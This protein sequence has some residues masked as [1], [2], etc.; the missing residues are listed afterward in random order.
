MPSLSD[1]RDVKALN[2]SKVG[3]QNFGIHL[4]MP[5]PTG[6]KYIEKRVDKKAI[7]DG[8]VEREGRLMAQCWFHPNT[9]RLKASDLNYKALGYCSIFTQNCELGS[10][11]GLLHRYAAHKERL[12]DEGFLW[13]VFWDMSLAINY[14]LT[15]TDVR[16]ARIRAAE[17]KTVSAVKDWNPIAQLDIKPA[18][19]FM[20]N[21]DSLGADKTAFPTL[22]MGDFAC[23]KS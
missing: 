21:E 4:V 19:F 3:G 13:K 12:P 15:D 6:E 9:I 10:L 5:K 1:F 22:I 23:S 14:F 18:K 8:Y 2:C 20:T 11:D 7:N 17:G 16:T